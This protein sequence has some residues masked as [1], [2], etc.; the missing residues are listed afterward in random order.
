MEMNNDTLRDA[1]L[2]AIA[3]KMKDGES[4]PARFEVEVDGIVYDITAS[5]RSKACG[6]AVCQHTGYV[7]RTK[8]EFLRYVPSGVV[9]NV[10]TPKGTYEATVKS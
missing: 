6:E 3:M 2:N 7:G 10:E 1:V 8:V 9:Y 4:M 5:G